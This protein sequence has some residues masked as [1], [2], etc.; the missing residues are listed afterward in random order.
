MWKAII[1]IIKN[2][3]IEVRYNGEI[4]GYTEDGCKEIEFLNND[5]AKKCLDVIKNQ[6]SEY[7]SI[8]SRSKI[9]NNED[10]CQINPTEYNILK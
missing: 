8:S 1:K 4:V 6:T 9:T 10:V 7:L 5:Y 2:M 3:K